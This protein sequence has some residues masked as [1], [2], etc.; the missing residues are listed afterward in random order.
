LEVEV[1]TITE[2]AAEKAQFFMEQEG[3]QGW[4]M[5]IFQAGKSCCGPSYGIDLIERPSDGDEIVEKDGLKVFLDK[6]CISLL[7]DMQLDYYEKGDE[8]GFML[9]G[10]AEPSCG[11]CNGCG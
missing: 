2:K 7:A 5:R 11:E 10:G 3:K 6:D 1:F 4:G 9:N 8:V